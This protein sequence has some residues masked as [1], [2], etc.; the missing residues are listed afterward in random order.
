MTHK[1]EVAKIHTTAKLLEVLEVRRGCYEEAGKTPPDDKEDW[2]NLTRENFHVLGFYLDH[3]IIASV[4]INIPKQCYQW[5][6]VH[7]LLPKPHKAI[8]VAK[9]FIVPK[10]RNFNVQLC[11]FREVHRLL[12]L[13]SR[14]HI[15]ISSD[16][17]LSIL[18]RRMNF[19]ST[20][21][22]LMKNQLNAVSELEVMVAKHRH[23]GIYGLIDG[24][25]KWF[26][27]MKPIIDDLTSSGKLKLSLT[28]RVH[29]RFYNRIGKIVFR[30]NEGIL[31]N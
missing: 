2:E 30:N 8:E 4:V 29:Y 1:I 12:R 21:V 7:N 5:L 28:E 22:T 16:K 13:N 15:V 18:Y 9:L 3:H 23:L 19:R 10:H 14:D 24:P 27:F 26:I 17:R 25:L 6:P 31:W 11:I 20:G